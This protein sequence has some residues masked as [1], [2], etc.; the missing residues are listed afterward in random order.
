MVQEDLN[1]KPEVVPTTLPQ[2]PKKPQ[3]LMVTTFDLSEDS[4]SSTSSEEA[5]QPPAN[6][7]TKTCS[8]DGTPAS[9]NVQAEQEV[10]SNDGVFIDDDFGLSLQQESE[11]IRQQQILIEKEISRIQEESRAFYQQQQQQRSI[12]DKPP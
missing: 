5:T 9:T 2:I 10:E 11:Q 8:P 7:D 6:N 3:D 4:S 1:K 12:P